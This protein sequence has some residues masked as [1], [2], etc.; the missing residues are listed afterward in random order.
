[1][2]D[3]NGAKVPMPQEL[4][5]TCDAVLEQAKSYQHDLEAELNQVKSENTPYM[6][7][8]RALEQVLPSVGKFEDLLGSK[9]LPAAQEII[10]IA[11][12]LS[13]T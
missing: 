2:A 11:S 8:V 9:V 1:M 3:E 5:E 4:I 7:H 6:H 10:E 13:L 12:R